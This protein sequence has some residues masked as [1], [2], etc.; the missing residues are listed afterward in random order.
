LT[1]A[2]VQEIADIKL[3]VLS[4]IPVMAKVSNH[5]IQKVLAENSSVPRVLLLRVENAG[6]SLE[7]NSTQE[8]DSVIV[9]LYID[10]CLESYPEELGEI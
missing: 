4:N 2:Q 10:Y 8:Y 7:N 6:I 3:R 5:V 1:K 9:G